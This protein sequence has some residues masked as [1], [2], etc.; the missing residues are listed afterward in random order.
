M[1][2]NWENWPD[3]KQGTHCW[4]SLEINEPLIWA[5]KWGANQDEVCALQNVYNCRR[6]NGA[7]SKHQFKDSPPLCRLVFYLSTKKYHY[8]SS[9]ACKEKFQSDRKYF[10]LFS[11]KRWNVRIGELYAYFLYTRSRIDAKFGLFS[12]QIL[13]STFV[14]RPVSK[15]FV[16]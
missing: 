1:K 6:K 3:C 7:Y 2:T 8:S 10:W 12:F 5:P 4:R 15:Q 16:D 14:C 11:S 13:I 9:H